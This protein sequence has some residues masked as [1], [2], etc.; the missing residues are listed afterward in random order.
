MLQTVISAAEL[1]QAVAENDRAGI[2]D[3]LG[4][5]FFTVI[6][7]ARQLEVDP[8]RSLRAANGKFERRFRELELL[9][10][11]KQTM[12]SMSLEEMEEIWQ[13]VKVLQSSRADSEGGR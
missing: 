7:L 11:G 5:L 12:S 8:A 1:E 10:G 6:N 13:K 4:D 2:E 9:A 3:E